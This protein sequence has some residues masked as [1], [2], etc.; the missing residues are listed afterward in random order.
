M[1]PI[2]ADDIFGSPPKSNGSPVGELV[3]Q[4]LRVADG[5]L[6]VLAIVVQS[7]VAVTITRLDARRI[8]REAYGE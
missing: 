1:L 2:A 5:K 7:Q 4:L 3:E 8:L 6:S